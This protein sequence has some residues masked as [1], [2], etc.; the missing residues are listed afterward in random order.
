[1]EFAVIVICRLYQAKRDKIPDDDTRVWCMMHISEEC[2]RCE[3]SHPRSI[4]SDGGPQFRAKFKSFCDGLGIMHKASLPYN[5]HSNSQAK[6][7]ISKRKICLSKI[8]P[9]PITL[10]FWKEFE[11]T[12]AR[13]WHFPTSYWTLPP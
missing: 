5:P 7:I 13:H 4:Q 1:M 11:I 10:L 8:P 2:K 6:S 12:P 3:S 9:L